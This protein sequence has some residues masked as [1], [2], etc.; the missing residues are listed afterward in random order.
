VTPRLTLA[1]SANKEKYC[2]HP[3]HVGRYASRKLFLLRQLLV[4]RRSRMDHKRLR[5]T[6]SMVCHHLPSKSLRLA[7]FLRT[8]VGQVARKSEV[9]N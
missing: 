4:R 2:T 6:Y 8:D 9:I 5:I 3:N 1:K 7:K